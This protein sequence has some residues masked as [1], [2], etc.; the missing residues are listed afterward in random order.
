[1]SVRKLCGSSRFAPLTAIAVVALSL[2]LLA[3]GGPEPEPGEREA[4]AGT[5]AG[6]R[7]DTQ[8]VEGV[9]VMPEVI[10]ASHILIAYSGAEM[11]T[12]ERTRDE[13]L[14]LIRDLAARISS[15]GISFEQAAMEH[16]E[17]PSGS[18]G[19]SLGQ[20]GRGAMVS[21]FEDA[22]FSL[23]VGEISDVVE[24]PFGFH[25]IKRTE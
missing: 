17:C 19:G 23:G 4:G 25:L 7:T 18:R 3:C 1:M 9:S 24:T 11:A 15:G 5:D 14:A 20:F 10:T 16:S 13:A 21:S 8:A 22:A 2:S 12:T 6:I